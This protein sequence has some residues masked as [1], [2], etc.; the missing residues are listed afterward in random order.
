MSSPFQKQFIANSPLNQEKKVKTENWGDNPI[1][2][3]EKIKHPDYKRAMENIKAYN[4]METEGSTEFFRD[5]LET[6]VIKHKG[7]NYPLIAL[8]SD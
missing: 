2:E 6:P 3:P 7:K 8:V 5:S 1:P 4:K